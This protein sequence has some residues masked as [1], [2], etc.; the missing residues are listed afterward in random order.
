MFV[1]SLI[2][3]FVLFNIIMFFVTKM[4]MRD[5]QIENEIKNETDDESSDNPD[6]ES[7]DN[8]DDSSSDNLDDMDFMGKQLIDK[9]VD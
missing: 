7:S 9:K 4:C 3:L 6:D 8:P 2:V 5:E 1:L